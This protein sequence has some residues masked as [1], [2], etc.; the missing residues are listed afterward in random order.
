M[1]FELL[2]AASD[3]WAGEPR[4]LLE[5][6]AGSSVGRLLAD[7]GTLLLYG[8]LGGAVMPLPSG[9]LIRRGLRLRG[10]SVGA[11]SA[12]EQAED[13]ALALASPDLF[14][15]AATYEVADFRHAVEHT[16]RRGRRGTV[17]LAG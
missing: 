15:V 16:G 8:T 2:R 4:P 17:L 1:V 7:R 10:V 3:A 14:E 13:V 9:P 5:T 11:W 6:A 12:A